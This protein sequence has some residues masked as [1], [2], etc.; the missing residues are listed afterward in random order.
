[1][2]AVD[3]TDAVA[4]NTETGVATMVIRHRVARDTGGP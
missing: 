1:M 4:R 3:H 2:R